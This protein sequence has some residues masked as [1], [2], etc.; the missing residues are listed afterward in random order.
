MITG[1]NEGKIIY[2]PVSDRLTTFKLRNG[3]A[4]TGTVLDF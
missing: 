2:T 1:S 3:A 4:A